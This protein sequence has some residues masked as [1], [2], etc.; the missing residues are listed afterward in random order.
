MSDRD[1]K[2]SVGHMDNPEHETCR[3]CE[4]FKAGLTTPLT[5]VCG[6]YSFTTKARSVCDFWHPTKISGGTWE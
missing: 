2:L 5:G 3:N 1:K 4:A 6:S